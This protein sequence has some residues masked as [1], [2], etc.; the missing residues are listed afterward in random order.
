[1]RTGKY[2]AADNFTNVE[3]MAVG[4]NC[5]EL[6]YIGIGPTPEFVQGGIVGALKAMNASK[7]KV[8]LIEHE[9]DDCTFRVTW[10]ET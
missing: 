5:I 9:G 10:A 6:H 7:P 2:R 3:A 8:D 1:M 4:P